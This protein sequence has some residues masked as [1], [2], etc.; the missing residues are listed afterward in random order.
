MLACKIDR[1]MGKFEVCGDTITYLELLDNPNQC[2]TL[3][4][5][6]TAQNFGILKVNN[7]FLSNTEPCWM[8]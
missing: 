3:S 8:W 6:M 7:C 5:G 4:V 1:Y 2:P